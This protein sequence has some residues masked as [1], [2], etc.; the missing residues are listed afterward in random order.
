MDGEYFQCLVNIIESVHLLMIFLGFKFAIVIIND[1]KLMLVHIHHLQWLFHD[2]L[3]IFKRQTIQRIATL[4]IFMVS[5]LVRFQSNGW[6]I[7]IIKL[8]HAHRVIFNMNLL[9]L[10]KILIIL[11]DPSPYLQ[12]ISQLESVW[13]LF[14]KRNLLFAWMMELF[15]LD[16]L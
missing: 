4:T 11:S 12:T 2:G 13:W 16:V 5:C 9:I 15:L 7:F 8:I 3:L 1:L 6:I 10:F 14:D